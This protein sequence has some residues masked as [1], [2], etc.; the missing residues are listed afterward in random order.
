MP[1]A[2]SS[3]WRFF[4]LAFRDLATTGRKEEKAPQKF[5][6]SSLLNRR[7]IIYFLLL[8]KVFE[9]DCFSQLFGKK[10]DLSLSLSLSWKTKLNMNE[11]RMIE[12]KK[13]ANVSVVIK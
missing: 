6:Q 13:E 10:K 2:I 4:R 7:H 5:V 8:K 9:N 11:E 1:G 3:R 12:R